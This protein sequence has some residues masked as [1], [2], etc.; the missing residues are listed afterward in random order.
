MGSQVKRPHHAEPRRL[1]RTVPHQRH[2]T[3]DPGARADL[4][5]APGPAPELDVGT[6]STPGVGPGP[7]PG[8]ARTPFL[9]DAVEPPLETLGE[10]GTGIDSPTPEEPVGPANLVAGPELQGWY[11]VDTPDDLVRLRRD[12]RPGTA[13]AS[14][15]AA[16]GLRESTGAPLGA[17]A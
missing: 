16:L 1:G 6:A 5:A 7:G 2:R 9:D 4:G 13:T 3:D 17:G 15:L 8:T 12:V 14:A 11:D 10:L